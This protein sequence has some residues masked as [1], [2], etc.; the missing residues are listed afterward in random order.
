MAIQSKPFPEINYCTT[1][2]DSGDAGLGESDV[3]ALSIA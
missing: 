2:S 3:M 1:L